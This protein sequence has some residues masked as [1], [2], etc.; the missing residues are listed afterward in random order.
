MNNAVAPKE[1][2]PEL[3]MD[4]S[5]RIGIWGEIAIG[6]V[7]DEYSIIPHSVN[8]SGADIRF[9]DYN[10]AIEI[11]N[12][13]KPHAYLER[14]NSVIR[15]LSEFSSKFHVSTFISPEIREM[16]EKN[17]IKVIGLGFQIIHPDY[18][19]FYEKNQGMKNKKALN[20]RTLKI[21]RNRV[22]SVFETIRAQQQQ[23]ESEKLK[24]L[25]SGCSHISNYSHVCSDTKNKTKRTANTFSSVELP[26]SEETISFNKSETNHTTEKKDDSLSDSVSV[27]SG[28]YQSSNMKPVEERSS[29]DR[30]KEYKSTKSWNPFVGCSFDCIYCKPSFKDLL[31]WIGSMRHCENCQNYSPHEHPE[32]L[33]RI[34][35]D[36][37][38]FVCEDGDISFATPQFMQSVFEAM[39]QDTIADRKWF[40]QSK[41]PKCFR[42]Y[43]KLLPDNTYLVTTLETNRDQ[44]YDK[45]SKAPQPSQRCEDFLELQWDKKL[46]TIEPIMD[47]DL[48]IFVQWIMS[49]KPKAVF[50][51]YNS[52]PKEVSLPEPPKG[53]T[54]ELIQTLEEAGIQVLRKEMRD[55]SV[56][57]KAYRDFEDR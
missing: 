11:W 43:L 28:D 23:K 25:L 57:K 30:K 18:V 26:T 48:D 2:Y 8:E 54:L 36:K 15:N 20:K 35:K 44:D 37:A 56:A 7:F 14:M 38:I 24:E 33:D 53:K 29:I 41:N 40:L 6:S 46:I 50:I 52:K 10:V 42:K 22:R 19:D 16:E 47:F 32:R 3:R 49:I 1:I 21:I 9:E 4:Y 27:V 55:G 34:P 39:R 45:F 31:A 13:S 5:N 17:G 51:G 12:H